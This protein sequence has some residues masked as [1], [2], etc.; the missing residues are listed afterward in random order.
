RFAATRSRSE[1]AAIP[2]NWSPDF[3]SFALA[4]SL[5]RS[6]K[7]KRSIMRGSAAASPCYRKNA[8]VALGASYHSLDGF[9]DQNLL[10]L[11]RRVRTEAG[12][13]GVREPVSRLQRH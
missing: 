11:R 2:A 4:N 7:S 12:Q 8:D 9:P 10:G 5:R 1:R 13:A 6:V 3:S